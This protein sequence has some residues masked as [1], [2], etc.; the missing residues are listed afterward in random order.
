VRVSDAPADFARA[1]ATYYGG[2]DAAP[3][4]RGALFV[5]PWG[6][7]FAWGP[8][9]DRRQL[10]IPQDRI[11]GTQTN[12]DQIAN[13]YLALL[14]GVIGL[15]ARETTA[16]LIVET[17][18]ARVAAFGVHTVTSAQLVGVL[19]KYGLYRQNEGETA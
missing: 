14:F 19:S 10:A 2:L 18:D 3:P 12:T 5:S 4:L 17:S 15:A 6:I 7:Q 11:A 8:T 13:P 9:R 16:G 1:P